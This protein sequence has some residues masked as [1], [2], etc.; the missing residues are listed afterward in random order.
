MF[1]PCNKKN[2]KGK[3]YNDKFNQRYSKKSNYTGTKKK[4]PC[5]FNQYSSSL[6]KKSSLVG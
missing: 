6:K 2:K 1:L 5:L 4:R 3:I